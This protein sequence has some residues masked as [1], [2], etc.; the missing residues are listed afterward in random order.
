MVRKNGEAQGESYIP[1][2]QFWQRAS[3]SCGGEWREDEATL[4]YVRQLRSKEQELDALKLAP[5][6]RALNFSQVFG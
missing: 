1:G 4:R 6:Q 5:V 2:T 3:S